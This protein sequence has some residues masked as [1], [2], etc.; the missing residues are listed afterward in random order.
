M[1]PNLRNVPILGWNEISKKWNVAP[2]H[3]FASIDELT[4]EG[5]Y[6]VYFD[7]SNKKAVEIAHKWSKDL[8]NALRLKNYYPYRIDNNRMADFA[9]ATDTY[10]KTVRRIK[11]TLDEGNIIAKGKYNVI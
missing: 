10:W 5:F 11:Q 7:R 9:K 2:F 4:F 3:N 8:H 6:R 1:E